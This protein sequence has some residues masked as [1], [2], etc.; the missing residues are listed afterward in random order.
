[1]IDKWHLRWVKISPSC[2]FKQSDMC[3]AHLEYDDIFAC[4][5]DDCPRLTYEKLQ[6]G[7]IEVPLP[8]GGHQC[9]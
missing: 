6:A 9:I 7:I 3:V 8:E 1:M 2:R 4:N 5:P